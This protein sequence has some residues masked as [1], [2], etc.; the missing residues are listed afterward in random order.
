LWARVDNLFD[1]SDIF[2]RDASGIPI[3]GEL[4]VWEDGRNF[5]VGVAIDLD[6]G[7]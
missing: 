1:E 6:R 7:Q 3:P 5:H 2:R 4:Q